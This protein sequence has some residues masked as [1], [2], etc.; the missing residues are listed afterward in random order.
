MRFEVRQD[1][2]LT[3][4]QGRWRCTIGRAGFS[5]CKQE[6]DG[7][8]PIGEWPLRRVLY[9]PDRVQEV[10]RIALPVQVLHPGDLWCDDPSHADYNK[11]V[12]APHPVSCE[13]L[14][15]EDGVYDLIVPL[16][17]NDDPVISGRGSA[18][19]M[20]VARPGYEPTQGCVALALPD[21]LTMLRFAEGED[22][23]TVG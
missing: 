7:A 18:I 6:G 3:C 22:V 12:R 2:W 23:L 14:W 10:L 16:G 19:F 9:R 11:M 8:T 4:P 5:Q 17:Y 15:R 20:H 13:Q 21:L 1:G